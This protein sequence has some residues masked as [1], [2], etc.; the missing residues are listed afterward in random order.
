[1]KPTEFIRLS[2]PEQ[3]FMIAC[4]YEHY[5]EQEKLYQKSV[6]EANYGRTIY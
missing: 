2:A 6:R 3:A 4:L 1:M 5:E